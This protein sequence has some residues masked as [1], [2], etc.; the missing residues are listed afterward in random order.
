MILLGLLAACG[1]SDT[2]LHLQAM[3]E[4]PTLDEAMALCLRVQDPERLG[5]CAVESMDRFDR[6]EPALCAQLPAGGLW[7]DECFFLSTRDTDASLDERLARCDQA[8]RFRDFCG[9][10]QWA[11]E[12]QVL[13]RD[14]Q[15][16]AALARGAQQVLD[17]QRARNAWDGQYAERVWTTV[18]DSWFSTRETLDPAVC[19]T[20][21]PA[22]QAACAQAVTV[23]ARKLLWQLAEQDP[24]RLRQACARLPEA[25]SGLRVGRFG[26]RLGPDPALLAD[27]AAYLAPFCAGRPLGPEPGKLN[28]GAQ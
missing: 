3:T 16:P 9:M 2:A 4:A 21:D 18:W 19:A 22:H 17:S 12:V 26:P 1:P 7:R 27:G 24:T 10:H 5:Q 15:D 13:A 6:V 14:T 8:G 20:L 23:C 25:L 11:H 28:L